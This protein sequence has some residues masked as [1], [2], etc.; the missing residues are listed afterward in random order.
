MKMLCAVSLSLSIR[1]LSGHSGYILW[2]F[3][4]S[5][6]P[7]DWQS[8]GQEEPPGQPLQDS[9][10]VPAVQ[11]GLQNQLGHQHIQRGRR[12]VG[13]HRPARPSPLEGEG[14]GGECVNVCVRACILMLTLSRPCFLCSRCSSV[15]WLM[16]R[17]QERKPWERPRG[18]SSVTSSFRSF[19]RDTAAS[20]VLF[21][22]RMRR[23]EAATNRT[24]DMKKKTLTVQLT[25][26]W[27][28]VVNPPVFFVCAVASITAC[29][30]VCTNSEMLKWTKKTVKYQS[31]REIRS[32]VS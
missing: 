27:K 28:S 26:K 7:A 12:H 13:E 30:S 9:P 4:W 8:S 15:C 2:Q 5:N 18:S 25:P 24:V 1:W 11:S 19:W 20:P 32:S 6:Q 22:S 31:K 3:R 14:R 17:T 23:C 16:G 29:T 21:P 10:L